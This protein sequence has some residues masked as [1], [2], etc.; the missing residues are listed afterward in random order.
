[1]EQRGPRLSGEK[2]I[3]L[4]W[5]NVDIHGGNAAAAAATTAAAAA[6]KVK[7][8]NACSV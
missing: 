2:T 5:I 1:M 3:E 7:F 4:Q 6:R 8:P